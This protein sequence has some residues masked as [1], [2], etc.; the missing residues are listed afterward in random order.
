MPTATFRSRARVIDLLGRQQIAD[1]PTAVGELFKNSLDAGA[2]NVWADYHPEQGL[3]SFRDD[4]LG[5]RLH[6]VLEK[7]LI[8]A[9]ESRYKPADDGWAKFADEEQQKWLKKPSYGEKGIGRLS[10]ASLGRMALLWTVWGKGTEKRGTLCLVH[11]HLFQH[12]LKLFEDLPIPYAELSSNPKPSDVASLFATMQKNETIQA[13]LADDVWDKVLRDELQSD[14]NADVS[15]LFDGNKFSWDNGT[16]F[17]IFGVPFDEISALFSEKLEDGGDPYIKAFHAFSTFWDPFHDVPER[18]FQIHPSVRS[19]PLRRTN[20][21]NRF[22]QPSDFA[23]CDH[24]ICINVDANGFA[25]GRIEN[26]GAKPIEYSR[27]LMKLPAGSRSPGEF[28]VEIGY[29]Q[30]KK[31]DTKLP[32]DIHKEMSDRLQLAGGFSIYINNVRIQPYGSLDSDFAGFEQRRLKNAG[33]YY[34]SMLRMFGGVFFADK[35]Q[36]SL[37][38]KAGREGFIANGASKGLRFWLE[39]LFVDIADS[40]LG[41]KADREDK[42]ERREAKELQAAQERLALAKADYLERV[43]LARGWLRTYSE[44]IKTQVQKTRE[45][46]SR[47]TD[48]PPGRYLAECREG[49]A[50]LRRQLN[51]LRNSPATQPEGVLIDGDALVGVDDY[52]AKRENE[53]RNLNREIAKRAS[54][55]QALMFRASKMKEQDRAVTDRMLESERAIQDKVKEI[56]AAAKLK[57]T[58]L[59][60]DLSAVEQKALSE[61]EECRGSV[62]G[63]LTAKDIASDKSGA[64]A[65][66]LEEA[67]QS[68]ETLFEQKIAPRLRTLR[69]E[70]LHL[71]DEAGGMFLFTAQ[72]EELTRLKERQAFLVDMAQLGLVFEAANHEHEEQVNVVRHAIRQLRGK[73]SGDGARTLAAMSDAFDIIDERIRMFDP[74]LRRR[75]TVFESISGEEIEEFLRRRFD[76]RLKNVNVIAE[77]TDEFRKTKWANV[78]RPNFLGALHNLFL[79]ATYWCCQGSTDRRIRLSSSDRRLAVSDTGPGIV[80]RDTERIFEPGFSRRPGGR[81]LGLYI[82]REALHGMGYEL[83]C[84]EN[85]EPDALEGA[86]FVVFKTE[87][88]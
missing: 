78:K 7:W 35:G 39:D 49:L 63:E 26:Y 34:F 66:R 56:L 87:V 5:M 15:S 42:R 86:N 43:R 16:T 11:W 12:P 50:Q 81:G 75:S 33:R 85:T 20:S 18:L 46:I 53:L 68:Q 37:R 6:D 55:I 44:D 14:I 77:F 59:E 1:A 80:V 40:Y 67:I 30:G 74:L 3:V 2:R 23:Q 32:L 52:I 19:I 4:G 45:F 70:I 62:L 72:A 48:A 10:V 36:T 28:L 31:E 54:D 84:S 60:S 88:H 9:T 82:A 58:S 13:M 64:K 69:D 76:E 41:R 51:E 22:W 29:V 83:E 61:L 17:C 71:T 57:A 65:Q 27:Q 73:L 47:E 79:N 25:R 21:A 8:L 24:H 38:E